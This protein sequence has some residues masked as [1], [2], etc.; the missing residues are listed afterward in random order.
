MP[1]R[2]WRVSIESMS[3]LWA[4]C[5]DRPCIPVG[6]ALES[7]GLSSLP[8]AHTVSPPHPVSSYLALPNLIFGWIY[9]HLF[10][11]SFPGLPS[12]NLHL[13]RSAQ[14]LAHITGTHSSA[15]S[16]VGYSDPRTH[17]RETNGMNYSCHQTCFSNI[18]FTLFQPVPPFLFPLQHWLCLPSC[19][20][21]LKS[22]R[23]ASFV[24]DF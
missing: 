16:E 10:A 23:P 8:S 14:I 9:L 20:S 4:V 13:S 17:L 5:Q 12:L 7:A 3:L 22:S 2:A 15:E 24:Q 18:S 1:L 19:F 21:I 11:P 6:L